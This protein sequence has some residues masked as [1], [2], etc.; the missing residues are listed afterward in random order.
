VAERKAMIEKALLKSKDA[1]RVSVVSFDGLVVDAA[2]AAG[3]SILIRGLRDGTDLDYEMQMAGINAAL[4][5]A[6]RTM[7]LPSSPLVRHIT[8]SLVRQVAALG[9][10][11]GVRQI[12]PYQP[13]QGPA[14]MPG[15]VDLGE[16]QHLQ[17][18]LRRRLAP[19]QTT[20]PA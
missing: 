8:T 13:N 4:A 12:R 20:L 18:T 16:P 14:A 2:K 9:D 7:F 6:L 15:F 17:R 11:A 19:E 1:D 3:A 10:P 5:P